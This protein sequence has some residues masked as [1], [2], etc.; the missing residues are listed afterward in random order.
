MESE[1]LIIIIKFYL[2]EK[3]KM[4]Q[5]LKVEVEIMKILKEHFKDI[6]KLCDL[7]EKMVDVMADLSSRVEKIEND[8]STFNI[9][10]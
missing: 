1:D 9:E 2:V 5:E 10:S 4:T 3:T 6:D 8:L 7:L